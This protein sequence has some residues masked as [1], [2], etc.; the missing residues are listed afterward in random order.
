MLDSVVDNTAIK[1]IDA[2]K[3]LL[4]PF[5]NKIKRDTK[6]LDIIGID[7]KGRADLADRYVSTI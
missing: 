1:K 2:I 3:N 6:M 7:D 4:E 5:D